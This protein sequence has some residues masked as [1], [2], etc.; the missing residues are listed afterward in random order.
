M[1]QIINGFKIN[2][3]N[4]I[5]SRIIVDV[6]ATR[7]AIQYKYH[8][9]RVWQTDTNTPYFWDGTAWKSEL[10]LVVT[11]VDGVVSGGTVPVFHS[12]NPVKIRDSIISA[13]PDLVTINGDLS[14]DSITSGSID[15]S[16]IDTGT[17]LVSRLQKGNP[18]QV[19]QTVGTVVQW[20]NLTDLTIGKSTNSDKSEELKIK[21]INLSNTYQLVLRNISSTISTGGNYVSLHS[22]VNG[23]KFKD[24]GN[25]LR[26]LAHNGSSDNPPYSFFDSP[27]TGMY[28]PGTNQIGFSVNSN[29]IVR[30]DGNG[31][32]TILGSVTSPSITSFSTQDVLVGS[33]PTPTT[34]S[35][36]GFYFNSRYSGP[37]TGIIKE[38]K[39]TGEGTNTVS[40]NRY[41]LTINKIGTSQYPSISFRDIDTSSNSVGI[42]SS[43]AS[44][45][46]FVTGGQNR[47]II[48]GGNA[49]VQ[50]AGT[51]ELFGR[52]T[53]NGPSTGESLI[54]KSGS[55]NTFVVRNDSV[56]FGI[57]SEGSPRIRTNNNTSPTTP[58]YTWYDNDQ[59]GIY[60]PE[61]DVI[62]FSTSGVLRLKIED[63]GTTV[64]NNFYLP[65]PNGSTPAAGKVLTAVDGAGKS[66]WSSPSN[67]VDCGRVYLYNKSNILTYRTG[68]ETRN[69]NDSYITSFEV[70]F[71]GKYLITMVVNVHIDL[72]EGEAAYKDFKIRMA[73]VRGV[74]T[75]NLVTI[76]ANMTSNDT[77]TKIVDRFDQ[78]YTL[79]WAGDLEQYDD[80]EVRTTVINGNRS[81]V[82]IVHFE[83]T[84]QN[85]SHLSWIG[86][87]N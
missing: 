20:R 15:A 69:F 45:L 4:P 54:V 5:D 67:G 58:S 30:I 48:T 18:G 1:I 51:I 27:T 76:R 32:K 49:G 62:G 11:G 25:G 22:H 36:T 86:I 23:L 35:N 81:S 71:N 75:T 83:S 17:M 78:T 84:Q 66:E 53:I 55:D 52:N 12:S 16:F 42:Y 73:R 10:D 63:D 40:F 70:P 68:I 38:M 31:L 72:E 13:T 34:I 80:I 29:Q 9:L 64:N 43:S 65:S 61:Q 39:F 37:S 87:K 3:D 57:N 28:S 7:L 60:R 46:S 47:F 82:S 85:G 21:T 41:G 56:T 77:E 2:S 19:L 14:F 79:T 33:T 8:G 44:N 6:A 74:T 59:T 50:T 24:D 26:I